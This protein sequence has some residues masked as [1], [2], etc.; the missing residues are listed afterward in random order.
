VKLLTIISLDSGRL[1]GTERATEG[2]RL[3]GAFEEART[4]GGAFE[5]EPAL[6]MR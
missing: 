5:G 3:G 1:G 4:T 6:S 2:G